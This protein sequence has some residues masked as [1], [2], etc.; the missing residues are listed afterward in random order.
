MVTTKIEGGLCNCLFMYANV[1]AH[2]LKYG[3]DYCI[4]LTNNNPHYEGQKPYI[5]PNV[6]YCEKPLDLPLYTE[7]SFEYEEIP[8]VDN[9]TFAGYFQTERYFAKYRKEI[10][11]A[12]GFEWKP[13][14]E[15]VAIHRRMGDYKK[16]NDYH[17][18]VSDEYIIKAIEYFRGLGYNKFMVFSDGIDEMMELLSKPEFEGISIE[19]SEGRTEL[20]DLTIASCCESCIGSNST[21]SWWIYYLNQNP[22]KIGVF[23]EKSKWFGKAL[24]HNVT[25][26]YNPNW[27]LI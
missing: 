27:V 9:V 24:N 14:P 22:N 13:I 5:F 18:V 7:K 23:P 6:N 16:L 17:P 25:D 26:L 15:T 20:E 19:Y 1:I 12:F 3:L 4:P 8:F 10:L 21:F 11:E 2:S